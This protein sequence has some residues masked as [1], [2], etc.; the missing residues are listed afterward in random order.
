[1]PR[2]VIATDKFM[3]QVDKKANPTLVGASARSIAADDHTVDDIT[4][5]TAVKP[6]GPMTDARAAELDVTYA[7]DL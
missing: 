2:I 5:Q 7:P 6:D 3:G 4:M 1:M